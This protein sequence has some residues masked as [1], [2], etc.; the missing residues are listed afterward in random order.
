[1]AC[2][3]ARLPPN[4]PSTSGVD[5]TRRACTIFTGRR[6][7]GRRYAHMRSSNSRLGPGTPPA[8]PEAPARASTR[9]IST[10][11]GASLIAVRGHTAPEVRQTYARAGALCHQVR[12]S[13]NC[14]R[15]VGLMMFHT[16]RGNQTARELGVRFSLWPTLH[17]VCMT[18][19][20]SLGLM[21]CMGDLM[22][23]RGI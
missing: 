16:D 19:H 11:L 20:G 6:E 7:R 4:W 8:A 10:L 13:H 9:S 21:A 2:G 1:M 23:G 15:P 12:E 18:A 17:D 14:L 3:P 5:R 22:G